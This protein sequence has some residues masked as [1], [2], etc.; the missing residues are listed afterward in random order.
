MVGVFINELVVNDKQQGSPVSFKVR[1]HSVY[2]EVILIYLQPVVNY[3]LGPASSVLIDVGARFP[4]CMKY[5]A[6]VPPT[7]LIGCKSLSY[8]WL[9]HRLTYIHHRHEQHGKSSNRDLHSG[10]H[11]WLWWYVSSS[12][13]FSPNCFSCIMCL[14]GIHGDT[15]NQWFRS[16]PLYI[17]ETSSS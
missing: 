16:V 1:S 6:D 2:K 4:P 5:V 12:P 17:Y 3:M 10:R 13:S 7:T 8:Y 9:T 11:M 15:P 14:T